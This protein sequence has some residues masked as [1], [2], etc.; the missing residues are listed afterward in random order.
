ML[1]T[2]AQPEVQKRGES[3]QN[4]DM[5]IVLV[6]WNN[7]SYLDPC[8][9]S[10]YESRLRSTF[11][12][13]VVD[14]GSTDGSQ[15]M[16]AEKYPQVKLIQNEGNVGLGKASNQ[17][18]E[19]TRGRY[20]LLLNNDT[21]VNRDSLDVLV[22][23][24]EA[25]PEAGAVAGKLLNPD[26]SFQ[27][28]YAGFSSLTEEFLI[29]THLGELLWSGYPSHGDSNETKAVGWLSSACL[30]ARRSALDQIG[31][32]DE[33]Y[34]IYGDEADLQ[35]RLNK[36]GWKVYFL[37]TSTIIHFGGRSMDRWKR[38]K[39]VYRGK[40]LFYQKNYGFLPTLL[41]R[42]LFGVMSLLK[43]VVWLFGFMIPSRNE[44][45]RKELRSNLDVLK[46]CVDLK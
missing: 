16:L 43:L 21:L 13:V 24:L 3:D 37:P 38:R 35:Y 19:A 40:M 34:F 22:N 2:A 9:A 15:Q 42:M 28:G 5:S 45:A 46:L 32:L 6:C 20:V 44:Q 23:F 25:H 30:L 26:G 8:L 4:P 39:M 1:K 27:S 10:L 18:I 36:A 7:K 33:G 41:L 14:N 31:L 29:A 11:D 17:G 12:V